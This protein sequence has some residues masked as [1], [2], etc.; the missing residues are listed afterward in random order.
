MTGPRK[1]SDGR[2]SLETFRIKLKLQDADP[3][4]DVLTP[5]Q[6]A[7]VTRSILEHNDV[8]QEHFFVLLLDTRSRLMGY[9][10]ISTGSLN[11]STIHPRDVFKAAI[12]GGAAAVILAHNHPSGDP[13]PSQEDRNI[14]RILSEAG[15]LLEMPVYDHVVVGSEGYF[16]FRE[17]G[18]IS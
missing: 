3:R 5:S 12:L 2:Y 6:A 9:K 16:S 10:L 8:D 1:L 4:S 15:K 7:A 11:A 13:R 18:L 14:T 17:A